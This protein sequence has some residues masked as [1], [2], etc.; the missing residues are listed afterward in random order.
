MAHEE[1]TFCMLCRP[2]GYT[3]LEPFQ[4]P[5]L[6]I[7]AVSTDMTVPNDACDPLPESTPDLSRYLVI[8]RR[9]T[10]T[11]VQKLNNVAAKG[12][13]YV[14]IYNNGGVCS[15]AMDI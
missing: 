8:I 4:W 15:L 3:S 6:P 9:G 5:T 12:A 7:Y 2:I 1:L 11:F 14:F 10:C 13:K